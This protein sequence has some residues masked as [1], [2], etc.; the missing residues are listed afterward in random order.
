MVKCMFR[1]NKIQTQEESS[2]SV[3]NPRRTLSESSTFMPVAGKS[4]SSMGRP[5]LVR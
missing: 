4:P 2:M 5:V 3:F 1:E